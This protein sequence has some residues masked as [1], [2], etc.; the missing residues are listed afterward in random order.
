MK[1]RTRRRIEMGRSVV[2]FSEAHP[3]S[4]AGYAKTLASLKDRLARA[5][6]LIR[7][8]RDGFAEVRGATAQKRDLRRIIV[9][10]QLRHVSQVAELAASEVPEVL[11]KFVLPREQIPY[12]EFQAAAQAILAEALNQ[13]ELLVKH[14]LAETLLADLVT[15]VELFDQAMGQSTDAR[16]THVTA[17][18]E[19]DAIGDEI[20]HLV[21]VMDTLN[22]SRFH[23]TVE[24]L[25]AWESASNVFGPVHP[26]VEPAA[27]PEM[28]T[29]SYGPSKTAA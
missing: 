29:P 13:K 6:E 26:S 14:G 8:Q 7:L 16:R 11:Q 4:S 2:A 5:A 3:D 25:A 27:P 18:A 21:K 22:R 23:G 10:T 15:N 1:S 12:L 17:S 24:L 28:S 20:V 19:L 9:R